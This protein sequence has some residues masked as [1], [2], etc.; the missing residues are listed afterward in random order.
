MSA[1]FKAINLAFT[2]KI[3]RSRVSS[4]IF[5]IVSYNINKSKVEETL[6]KALYLNIIIDKS[7]NRQYDRVLNLYINMLKLGSYYIKSQLLKGE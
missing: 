4:S 3:P 2:A 7:N 5:L 1:F 6:Q